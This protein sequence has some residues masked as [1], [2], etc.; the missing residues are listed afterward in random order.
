LPYGKAVF[1][2]AAILAQMHAPRAAGHSYQGIADELNGSGIRPLLG[3]QWCPNVVRRMV[4]RTAPTRARRI[5]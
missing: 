2:D 5:A 1:T 4:L 3:A